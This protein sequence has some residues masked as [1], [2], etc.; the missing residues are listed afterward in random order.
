VGG[1]GAN[2]GGAKSRDI[3]DD[4]NPTAVISWLAGPIRGIHFFARHGDAL[5]HNHM[6]VSAEGQ[7]LR[8]S[9]NEID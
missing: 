5:K 8:Y 3:F 7:M 9:A 6:H 4:H 1:L 2:P